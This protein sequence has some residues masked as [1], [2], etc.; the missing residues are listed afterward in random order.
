MRV[1][2][3]SRDYPPVS[4]GV[5]DHTYHLANALS[6]KG[7]EVHVLTSEN[8]S[9]TEGQGNNVAVLPSVETWGLR[10]IPGIIREVEKIKP[11][12]VMLQYVPN[13]YSHYAMPL[14]MAMLAVVLRL[15]GHKQLSV[16]HE[17][18]YRLNLKKPKY[19]AV[20]FI[21]RLIAFIMHLAS[22]H[23]V[24]SIDFYRRMF[25]PFHCSIRKVPVGSNI[26]PVR[27]ENTERAYLAGRTAPDDEIIIS[28]FGTNPPQRKNHAMLRAVHEYNSTSSGP[29]LKVLFIGNIS[30]ESRKE[31]SDLSKELQI[32]K[33]VDFT[34]HLNS[35]DVY[36]YLRISN[37]FFLFDIW[38]DNAEG[39][40][41]AKSGSLIAAYAAGLPIISCRG[42]M[43]DDLFRHR[44][45]IYL[46]NDVNTDNILTAIKELIEDNSLAQTLVYNAVKT[47]EEQ[48][49]WPV[50]A[51]QFRNIFDTKQRVFPG[52]ENIQDCADSSPVLK[53]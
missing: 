23:S 26:L 22:H 3:I 35:K 33:F 18:A 9:I 17:I 16:F 37:L 4:G 27:F 12:L 8:K 13:M 43:T 20:I 42:D 1:V 49:D 51:E 6:D 29:F 53:T 52:P 15:K 5:G 24:T 30:G 38:G 36:K 44:E 25:R 50:I 45:N 40:A 46:I 39:G 28:T 10:G 21:Q 41:S 32:E 48:L 11:D 2:L 34:G 7:Y 47:Y 19:W 14:Q 31:L